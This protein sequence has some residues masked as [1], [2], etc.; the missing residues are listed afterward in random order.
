VSNSSNYTKDVVVFF[1]EL[2]KIK[3][4]VD[5]QQ[6]IESGKKQNLYIEIFDKSGD[7]ISNV[8][9]EDLILIKIKNFLDFDWNKSNEIVYLKVKHKYKK[10][11]I[12]D[13]STEL[14]IYQRKLKIQKINEV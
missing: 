6:L 3:P 11:K 13:N 8:I 12:F 7:I 2:Y 1:D 10:F 5:I 9:I 14:K 4:F